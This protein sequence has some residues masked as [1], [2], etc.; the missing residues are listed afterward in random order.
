[1]T[2]RPGVCPLYCGGGYGSDNHAVG[3]YLTMGQGAISTPVRSKAGWHIIKVVE[4]RSQRQQP[5]DEVRESARTKALDAMQSAAQTFWLQKLRAAAKV[6]IHDAA[7][8][9]FVAANKF[10]GVA[11]PQHGMK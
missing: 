9:R 5:L 6:E 8:K 2:W 4:I 10:E 1:M 7:I 3:P 11:P